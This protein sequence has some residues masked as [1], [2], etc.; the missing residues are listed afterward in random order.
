MS[1]E[2][3]KKYEDKIGSFLFGIALI[4]VFIT[5]FSITSGNGF[6][7]FGY[8]V[9]DV[10]TGSMEPSYA[11]GDLLIVKTIPTE[12]IRIG[13]A[14][15]FKTS[16]GEDVFLTHRVIGI[17]EDTPVGFIT[18]GDNNNAADNFVV[19]GDAVVG[20]VVADVKKMGIALRFLRFVVKKWYIFLPVVMLLT[21]CVEKLTEYI[22]FDEDIEKNK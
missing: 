21:Y 4:I 3:V 15:T 22:K 10:A 11:P 8:H 13:D 18:K 7:L 5:A 17:T 14:I 2:H 1:N 20:K 12:E 6:S 19:Y 16:V 9:F